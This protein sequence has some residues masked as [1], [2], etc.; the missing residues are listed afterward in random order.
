[1]VE[2]SMHAADAHPAARSRLSDRLA[3]AR[4]R[5][6]AGR[7]AELELFR[8]ALREPD[9]PFAVLHI[10]GPG[11]VGKTAL[12]NE[13]ARVAAEAG[14]PVIL[15]D[16]RNVEPSPAG[17]CLALCRALELAAGTPLPDLLAAW[18]SGALLIDTYEVLAPL[19]AWLRESLLPQLPERTVVVVA[20]REQPATAWRT[21]PGWDELTRV[22]PLRN[23]A[24]VESRAYL[25]E[26]RIPQPQHQ[27]VLE[28]TH[29]HPL[30]LALVADLL[31]RGDA[32]VAGSFSHNADVVQ[33]LLER[34]VQRVPS[35]RHREALEVC[36]HARV[37]TEALLAETVDAEDAP[38]LFAWLRGLSFI[39][40]GP[41]GLFPHDLAREVL[42]ADLR[43]RN[44]EIY[45]Q[46]NQ[47]VRGSIVRRIQATSGP[48]QQHAFFDLLYLHRHSPIMRPFYQWTMLGTN[49]AE[50]AAAADWPQIVATVGRHDGPASAAIARHW[51]ERQPRSF[52]VF[53]D[54]SPCIAGF[55]CMLALHETTE[56]D[57]SVDPALR[58]AE[59][60]ALRY[61]PVRPGEASVYCRFA[62]SRDGH[63]PTESAGVWDLVSLVSLVH[64][65]TTPRLAWSYVSV[66]NLDY[67]RTFFHYLRQPHGPEATFSVGGRQFHVFAHD[68]RAE[69][70]LVWLD[71]MHE[72]ELDTGLTPERLEVAS[73]APVVVLSEPEFED[74]VRRALRAYTR[75]DVLAAN[76]LLRSR[77][78]VEAGGGTPTGETLRQLLRRAAE[79]LTAN[80][81]DERLYRAVNRT[82]LSPAPTQEQAAELLG[83]PFSTYRS[84][85]TAG[86]ERMTDWLWQRELYGP[87]G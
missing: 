82:Y 77:L 33:V 57:H 21:D 69:P 22:V 71:L 27:R 78:A 26:R 17:F 43:W 85:L 23:L 10:Y 60:H 55:I 49:Y 53:R 62:M 2:A 86:I 70:P 6:F 65:L 44:A 64:W 58:P 19:D 41:H 18:P 35:P 48:E 30:A 50:P 8:S 68:W 47:R 29:G 5:R 39:E 76:P 12:L 80:P 52:T 36:A 9:R 25:H 4:R 72:R 67:W 28:W 40:H 56:H 66:P 81:R 15:L 3:E 16:G 73:P 34:F 42:D 63:L 7:M 51:L 83:L 59:A 61:G 46:L 1:M 20:G 38:R 37:T 14:W 11:G 79:T 74:A 54:G 87:E 84:H 45:R 24:P 31:T 32:Q 13:Y 75:A